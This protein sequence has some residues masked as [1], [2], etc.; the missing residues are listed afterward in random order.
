MSNWWKRSDR[1][2]AVTLLAASAWWLRAAVFVIVAAVVL[3]A[4]GS[5]A[6]GIAELA[7]AAAALIGWWA[8][9]RLPAPWARR[10]LFACLVVL[11]AVGGFAAAAHHD[12]SVLALAIVSMLAAGADLPLAELLVVFLAG[13]LAVVIGAVSYG[14]TDLG[15]VLE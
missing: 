14:D 13:V 5:I 2:A 1:G 6:A 10:S 8:G 15:T 12:T 11:T 3:S 7:V 9:S 4:H